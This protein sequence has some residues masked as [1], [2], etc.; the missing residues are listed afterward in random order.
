MGESLVWVS[1]G[2]LFFVISM[3]FVVAQENITCSGNADCGQASTSIAFCK[4][5]TTICTTTTTPTCK[6]ASTNISR[7]NNVKKDE[8]WPC[9]N[10]CE[11]RA[12][13]LSDEDENEGDENDNDDSGFGNTTRERERVRLKEAVMNYLNSTE[14]PENCTC[15]GSTIKCDTPEGRVMTVVAGR[16]GNVIIQTKTINATTTVILIKNSTGVYGNFTGKVKRIKY[17]PEQIRERILERLKLQDCTNCNMTL[18]EDGDYTMNIDGT[19]RAFWLFQKRR[20]VV[21]KVNSET[22]E[23][24]YLKK[25][26][27]KFRSD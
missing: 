23:V 13:K 4:N 2:I 16:S 9:V 25:P 6:N 20:V 21:G 14:C 17:D 3:S 19:Y 11:N 15:A 24:T 27:W 8:C 10:G 12:C 1:L 22:G 18:D 7:C 26:F 5:T